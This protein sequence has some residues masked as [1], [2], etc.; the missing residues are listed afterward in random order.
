VNKH[1]TTN[2]QHS[3]AHGKMTNKFQKSNFKT[4]D[5]K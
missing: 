5:T 2:F 3:Y 1:Q 4:C